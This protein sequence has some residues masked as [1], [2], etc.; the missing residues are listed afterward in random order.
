[1]K[2]SLYLGSLT[3]AHYLG[4][5]HS[6]L[7][8]SRPTNLFGQARRHGALPSPVPSSGEL[9]EKVEGANA[10]G[11]PG[12]FKTL[13]AKVSRLDDKIWK[14]LVG[15]PLR[16]LAGGCLV[17]AGLQLLPPTALPVE[18]TNLMARVAIVCAVGGAALI[19]FS[20]STPAVSTPGPS[21]SVLKV[22]LSQL[23]KI[24][25]GKVAELGAL[26]AALPELE[27]KNNYE[28]K[29]VE[30]QARKLVEANAAAQRG[31]AEEV[32]ALRQRIAA[33]DYQLVLAGAGGV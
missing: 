28:S 4:R 10:K 33:I 25:K 23:E 14:S 22:Q 2:G 7:L 15:N 16:L 11:S 29:V 6:F 27:Q 21:L 24:L 3:L 17:L 1:M 26:K 9:L 12:G 20:P 13:K 18:L 8:S 32:P 30:A 19:D 31:L 5:G